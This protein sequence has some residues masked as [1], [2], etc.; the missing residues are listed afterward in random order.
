MSSKRIDVAH[1]VAQHTVSRRQFAAAGVAAVAAGAAA[2]VAMAADAS[3]SADGEHAASSASSTADASRAAA[4]VPTDVSIASADPAATSLV[5]NTN[6][7]RDRPAPITD[8]AQTVE[9]DVVVVGGGNG[10]MIAACTALDEGASVVVLEKG[11]TLAMAKEAFASVGSVA[12]RRL[13]ITVDVPELLNFVRTTESGDVDLNLYRTWAERSGEMADWLADLLADK[14]LEIVPE[15]YAPSDPDAYYPPIGNNFYGGVIDGT[16][17]GYQPDGPQYG[18]YCHIAM[19]QEWF[20]EHGGDLRLSTPALQLVQDASGRVTGVIAQAEDGSHLQ[21][22]AARGVILCT[23]GYAANGD[24]MADLAP[25]ATRYC[26]GT[27]ALNETGDGIRMALWAGAAL[28]ETGSAMVWNRALMGDGCGFGAPW[29]GAIFLPG[30]QPFL[31]V[32]QRGERF[33]NED[34]QYPM[35]FSSCVKQP[36]HYAWEIFD[37]SCWEDIQKFDTCGC[38]RLTPA[39]SGQAFNADVYDCEQLSE[40]HLYAAWIDPNVQSGALK[41]CDTLEELAEAMGMDEEAAETFLQTVARYNELVSAG[42]DADFGK[43]AYRMSAV[44]TPPF[45]AAKMSGLILCTGNGI[46][47]DTRSRALDDDGDVI[48]GLYVCGNDQGGFYPHNYPSCLTGMNMGRVCTFARI[49][50]KDALGVA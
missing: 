3:A 6:G 11:A 38:S 24:M 49:A 29:G 16:R 33:M 9:A 7:W 41:R 42:E 19:L 43:P 36:G 32:N 35:S 20:E 50:A 40:E 8:V 31:H 47:T 37:G 22:N 48:P 1:D 15:Y 17:F 30:S 25:E 14:G 34:Q 21:V 2:R 26:A 39:P 5:S 46:Y 13:G 44:D 45:Y 27:S 10:G 18:A 4:Y 28:E 23:G 12:Q